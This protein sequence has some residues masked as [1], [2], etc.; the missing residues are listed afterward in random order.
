M[1]R[2][3]RGDGYCPFDAEGRP[4]PGIGQIFQPF[5]KA[6]AGAP[7]STTWDR[8]GSTLE[9]RFRDDGARGTTDVYLDGEGSYP[10]GWVVE[11]SDPEGTWSHSY[12]P[13][14]DVLSIT[15]PRTGGDHAVCVKPA[16]AAPGCTPAAP[17][18][19]APDPG[20]PGP[21][22]APAAADH[23]PPP[24]RPVLAVPRYTG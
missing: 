2:M 6:I 18:A 15:T 13:D 16:G 12:D 20:G 14:T 1:F 19:P 5:A 22:T 4:R 3:C 11:A 7:T 8:E 9:V 24:A 21:A 23:T 10:D 17:A